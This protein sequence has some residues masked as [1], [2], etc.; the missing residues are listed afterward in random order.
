M[1]EHS[2]TYARSKRDKRNDRLVA[3]WGLVISVLLLVLGV[4]EFNRQRH[5]GMLNIPPIFDSQQ[6]M[7]VLSLIQRRE[8]AITHFTRR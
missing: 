5:E 6:N 3:L 4:L 8:N 7:Q 2:K 1:V